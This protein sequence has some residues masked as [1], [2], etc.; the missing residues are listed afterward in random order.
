MLSVS[1]TLVVFSSRLIST[2]EIT[3]F[4]EGKKTP[5]RQPLS[6]PPFAWCQPRLA[7]PRNLLP[8][9]SH[10]HCPAGRSR[11]RGSWCWGRASPGRAPGLSSS[12]RRSRWPVSLCRAG[13]TRTQTGAAPRGTSLVRPPAPDSPSPPRQSD[14]TST[15]HVS[16]DRWWGA[17]HHPAKH[18]TQT[19]HQSVWEDKLS[20]QET[21]HPLWDF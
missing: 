3:S 16:T 11:S 21:F 17:F 4:T 9:P 12:C 8:S 1:S 14:P 18:T 20:T 2:Q 19:C 7:N 10:L 15:K 5:H 13:R 6:G